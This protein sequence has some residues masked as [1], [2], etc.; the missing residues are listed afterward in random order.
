MKAVVSALVILIVMAA[1]VEKSESFIRAGRGMIYNQ[2]MQL[3][4]HVDLPENYEE[5]FSKYI[6]AKRAEQMSSNRGWFINLTVMQIKNIKIY[7]LEM[8]LELIST[9]IDRHY[10][11]GAFLLGAAMLVSNNCPLISAQVVVVF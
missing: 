6:D 10:Y 3:P 11:Y 4:Q 7:L 8:V 2:G 5:Y 9:F 1:V